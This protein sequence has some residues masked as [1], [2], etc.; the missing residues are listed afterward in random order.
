MDNISKEEK[1]KLEEK[2]MK[3]ICEMVP[4]EISEEIFSLWNEYEEAKSK[5]AIIVKDLDKMEM[6]FQAY[7]Y[8]IDQNKDL[9]EFFESTK[10]KI[11]NE[12]M[13]EWFQMLI[14]IRNEKN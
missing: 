1:H 4:K 11:Q 13:K 7:H 9:S 10:N 5:E 14:K 3:E 8:E 12:Q 2:A 6:L